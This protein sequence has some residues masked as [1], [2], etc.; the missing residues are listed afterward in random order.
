MMKKL[1]SLSI[2]LLLLAA[3]S[4]SPRNSYYTLTPLA[5]LPSGKAS[6]TVP[7]I[8]IVSVTLPELVDRPHLVVAASDSKVDILEFHRWAESLKAS[9]PR[10]MV[11][12]LSRLLGSERVSSYPQV[13][14]LDAT[15]LLYVDFQGFSVSDGVASMDVLWSLKDG[16]K[17]VHNGRSRSVQKLSGGHETVADAYSRALVVV[18]SDIAGAVSGIK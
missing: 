17:I 14:A 10:V 8:A 3:C 1:I 16:G 7:S 15:L 5:P 4:T 18:C 6:T 2:I 9:I 12:N 13:A 11:D